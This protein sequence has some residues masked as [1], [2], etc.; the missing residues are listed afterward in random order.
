MRR[1]LMTMRFARLATLFMAV[2]IMGANLFVQ[3]WTLRWIS[4]SLGVVWLSLFA[5]YT[6]Y[7]SRARKRFSR[8]RFA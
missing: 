3:S 2:A 1:T 6:Y 4:L 8:A 5:V 7:V